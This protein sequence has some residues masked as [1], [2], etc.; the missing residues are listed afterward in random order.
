MNRRKFLTLSAL[1]AVGAA[2]AGSSGV[3]RQAVAGG[4]PT[5][6]ALRIV[7]GHL[8]SLMVRLTSPEVP[9]ST[10]FGLLQAAAEQLGL[11]LETK[12]YGASGVEV[13]QLGH[14][15]NI[16]TFG[17]HLFHNG[18]WISRSASLHVV[19]LGDEV[20]A[21]YR[22]VSPEFIRGDSNIDGELDVSDA[23]ASLRHKFGGQPSLCPDAADVDDDGAL[24]LGDDVS[25]LRYLFLAGPSP[26]SPY[27]YPGPD[28][29]AD[30]LGCRW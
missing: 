14:R 26:S 3:V 17:W 13:S 5:K 8:D 11:R 20:L 1:G 23:V 27:P 24:T 7:F 30:A 15:V 25:L 18:V 28:L 22:S 10:I 6:Y 19:Q 9:T 21:M 29:T 16:P 2:L 4:E 12:D